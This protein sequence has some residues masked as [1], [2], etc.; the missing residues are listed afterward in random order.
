MSF[1]F[2]LLRTIAL[3]ALCQQ[4]WAAPV[5]EVALPRQIPQ[6]F[7]PAS[8]IRVL[9]VWATWC[10]PCVAEM[11]D[12]RAIDQRFSS[13]EVEIV[14]VSLD[15]VIPGSRTETR[16][17]VDQFLRERG[18]RFRNVYYTGKMNALEDFFRF[19]GEIPITIVFDRK[20]R[21]LVRHQGAIEKKAMI[22]QLEGLLKRKDAT[23]KKTAKNPS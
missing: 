5:E 18:V 1:R 7:S 17:R 22:R 23:L 19:E 14:G 3:L 21:E 10:A 2:Q 15:D 4:L 8:R 13:A 6:V 16:A 9:N 20:G 11:S 12:L